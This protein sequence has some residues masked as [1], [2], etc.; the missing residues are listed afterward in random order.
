MDN[1]SLND[2][3]TSI[4]LGDINPL[5][6]L[7]G[8]D[9]GDDYPGANT[10]K[11]ERLL[12]PEEARKG[13]EERLERLVT[14]ELLT[15]FSREDALKLVEYFGTVP[16]TGTQD[17]PG[18]PYDLSQLNS[19]AREY[20]IGYVKDKRVIEI[21]D[22][23]RKINEPFFILDWGAKSFEI[24]DAQYGV[25]GLT[26]LMRQPEGSALVC[27]FGVFDDG[28]LYMDGVKI[29][30]PLREYVSKLCKEIYR[31]TPK[32]GITLHGLEWDGDLKDAGFVPDPNTP[33]E[34]NSYCSRDSYYGLRVLRK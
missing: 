34:L 16:S 29:E 19:E 24:A 12:T 18:V 21:G 1:Y 28:M 11:I 22:A 8:K 27:S 7:R 32:G 17:Y 26:Y 33:K 20:L 4:P 31:V 25:D 10:G 5:R 6:R 3:D 23:G 14:P 15:Y 13:T 9:I 2:S 30:K